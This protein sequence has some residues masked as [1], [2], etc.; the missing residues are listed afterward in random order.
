MIRLIL[1]RTLRR[2]NGAVGSKLVGRFH[3]PAAR[4]SAQAAALTQEWP[5]FD[6]H[7]YGAALQD[8]VR[9]GSTLAGKAI[10][11]D[12]LK[13][14]DC[15]DL[16]ASN[17][18]LNLY[19]KAELF[20][21]A[22][23]L[24]DKMPVRNTVSFVTL[25]QG[26]AQAQQFDKAMELFAHLH[27]EGHE[28][29]PFVFTTS[30]KLLGAMERA[31]LGWTVH[32][33]IIKLGHNCNAFVGTALID[34]YALCGDVASAKEVFDGIVYKDMVSWTG[35]VTCFA[36]N[37]C[38]EEAL[39]LFSQMMRV[40]HK[41]NNY[42]FTSMLKACTSLDALGLGKCLHGS[43]LKTCY[44][45][46]LYVGFELLELYSKF[47]EMK[48]AHKLFEELPQK[49]VM[50]WS[51]M[52]SRHAQG[53][54][55]REAVEFFH[56]MRGARVLPN[57]F[58]LASMLQACATMESLELGKQIHCHASKVGL[59]SDV[60]VSNA[61]M[62]VY[63]K[64]GGIDVSE[65]I[66]ERSQNRND[67]SWN[68]LIVGHVQLGDCEKALG[69][70]SNMWR[71][72]MEATVVSYASTLR[73]CASL[74][75]LDPG[76]QVHT[77][78]IKTTYD[79]DPVVGNSLIHMYAKCGGI[80]DARL[81]FD[82]MNVRDVVSWNTM[83]S[84]YSMH[85]L[86]REALKA[87]EMM[88]ER[89]VR[90]NTLTFVGVLSAC[91]NGGL[92]EQGEA[93]FDSMVQDYD[94]EPCMEHYTCMVGLLGRLGHLDRAIKLIREIPFEP[95]VM[96]WR[97]LLGACVIHQNVEMGKIS[98]EKVLEMEPQD[99]ATYV[100]LSNIYAN[101]RRWDNV[102][103]VRKKMKKK[104]VKKEPGLSWIETQ[105]SVHCFK[106]GETSH[107]DMKLINGMLEWLN[108]KTR[109][110]GFN[111]NCD[112]VLLQVEEEEKERMLWLHS[113]R[114]ALAFA[115]IKVPNGGPIRIIK[116]LRICVDCHVAIKMIS[117]VV[118]R[119]I[120]VRDVN[121]YHHFC[122]GA[123]SCGDYW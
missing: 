70:F 61:L 85:G 41:P 46:D 58:T 9:G 67:V 22:N 68:T 37:E 8:C 12:A 4:F 62:D 55:S 92:L 119:E 54:R 28:L 113:E 116:N 94:I 123:C 27:R 77:L 30:L 60:F 103:F 48:D 108:M 88:K 80:K 18:L 26:Y 53:D 97:A 56:Q 79:K 93:Y 99:E 6:S 90:P 19:A 78:A 42:T 36:E 104:G 73:A 84:G 23:R 14:G 24:L 49:E 71:C 86:S 29:N 76:N 35:M 120:I 87:F 5:D 15:L 3:L 118:Q 105:G 112:A 82:T 114:L 91:S 45:L 72:Q 106:V 109:R 17:I 21:D 10:Q 83:I 57:Q 11:C 107:P 25:I 95:S 38:F 2:P 98:A 64:C 7:S 102:A 50:H 69:L 31:E 121:R 81:V 1:H 74:A 51:L 111:P 16:F 44:E 59:D 20:D 101:A 32:A 40:G 52:I 122:D 110:E 34:V 115:L 117:R 39:K 75:A 47:G 66:F 100:L 13:R 96:V 43:T 33:S 65:Q 63:A 89:K